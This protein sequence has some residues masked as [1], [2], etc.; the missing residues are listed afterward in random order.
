M[1]WSLPLLADISGSQPIWQRYRV[2]CAFGVQCWQLLHGRLCSPRLL[3]AKAKPWGCNLSAGQMTEGVTLAFALRRLRASVPLLAPF[4]KL[5]RKFLK[6]ALS[7]FGSAE[8]APRVQAILFMRAMAVQLP[9]PMLDS[10]LKVSGVEEPRVIH[11]SDCPLPDSLL[12]V[13][14]AH[15]ALRCLSCAACSRSTC[16]MACLRSMRGSADQTHLSCGDNG[17]PSATLP[18]DSRVQARSGCEQMCG[19]ACAAVL[20]SKSASGKQ[21]RVQCCVEHHKLAVS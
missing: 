17:H 9:P 5:Q 16:W 6:Q 18:T 14:P 1:S 10:V 19:A 21:T 12:L 15:T 4:D 2:S 11:I 7:V 3:L 13:N 20:A 8:N